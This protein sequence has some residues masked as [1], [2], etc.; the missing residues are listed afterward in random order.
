MPPTWSK[1]LEEL[2]IENYVGNVLYTWPRDKINE[3]GSLLT[4]ALT[5]IQKDFSTFQENRRQLTAA[6]DALF[7]LSYPVT[8][9]KMGEAELVLEIPRAF[10]DNRVENFA[11][12]LKL[13][14][15]IVSTCAE[16]ATGK[17]EKILLKEISTT[18]PVLVALATA[19]TVL[20]VLKAVNQILDA[21][22]K[23]VEIREIQART[24]AVGLDS[25]ITELVEAAAKK[26]IEESLEA[27][28]ASVRDEHKIENDLAEKLK[29]M[30]FKLAAMIDNGSRVEGWAIPH[31]KLLDEADEEFTARTGEVNDVVKQIRSLGAELRQFSGQGEPILHLPAPKEDE[32]KND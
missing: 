20:F 7:Y 27:F 28:I 10:F 30:M 21:Y 6:R 22:K 16:V 5:T 1:L 29:L 25:G 31:Q 12:R 23:I 32:K 8:S 3:S 24:K 17:P 14:D 26:K 18:D 9:L 19:P 13:F 2:D 4:D 15:Q 11:A